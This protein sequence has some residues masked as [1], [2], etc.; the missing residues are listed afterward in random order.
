MKP[1]YSLLLL[2]FVYCGNSAQG[3][4]G[5]HYQAVARNAG[6]G[7]LVSQAIKVRFTIL[8]GNGP[9]ALVQYMERHSTSTTPQGLFTL[10]IGK[11][12]AEAGSFGSIPWNKANQYLRID[13]DAANNNN[14]VTLGAVPFMSVPYAQYA[15][16]GVPG[17]KGDKGDKGDT[18]DKGNKG[19]PGNQGPA[20]AQGIQGLQGAAGPQGIAGPAGPVWAINSIGYNTNGTVAVNTSNTPAT[21]TSTDAVWLAKG[22]SGTN[23]STSFIGTTDAQPL[24]IKTNG[25]AATNERMRITANGQTIINGA[26]LRSTQDALEVFGT[27]YAGAINNFS[28]PINGYSSGSFAGVYGENTG[29][30]QGLLG[31]NI[32]TG[33]GVYGLNSSNGTGVYGM[34]FLAFGVVGQGVAPQG[35][36]VKAITTSATG[37]GLIALG[38][39]IVNFTPYAGG[40]GTSSYGTQAG[41]Y[42]TA[43]NTASGTGIVGLGNNAGPAA[44]SS[45][46][47]VQG[48]GTTYGVAGIVTE[49][50]VGNNHWGGY[51]DFMASSNGY[52][53]VGGR[54]GNTDYAILSG[55]AKSTIV[56][57]E[58][59]RNRIMYCMEAPEVL[60][61]D[62]GTGELKN[63]IAHITLDKLLA[64]NIKVDD[65]H[66][67]KV[68]IQP[69][70]EC[71]GVYVYNKTPDGFDVKELM[72][73]QSNISFTWQIVASR[74]D[75]TDNTGKVV[76]AF[77]DLRFPIGPERV[78]PKKI[79][80]LPA[81]ASGP[82]PLPGRLQ[83]KDPPIYCPPLLKPVPKQTNIIT[84]LQ[85]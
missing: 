31:K 48:I 83:E 2:L 35:A 44:L 66:P 12:T 4:S 65:K 79:E 32:S 76:S 53:W 15:A 46:A 70:G 28:F 77:A 51:F 59:N 68:F 63:G 69:E 36:G 78:I 16:N 18:G 49:P 37:T 43:T 25:S 3:L 80:T 38:N 64:R 11:G 24:L 19:D 5:I 72:K 29:A 81:Q 60:F 33:V 52:A 30:G 57:D 54:T 75:I 10:D 62:Y 6:G 39:S 84:T 55:G 82:S 34:S 41:L 1:V 61:Q 47:G 67:L 58:N 74:A 85:P 50:V 17:A 40:A 42:G 9:A 45:G 73:G 56:K 26:T 21:I 8:D 14:F 13:L 27:G 71:N 7:V 23:P 20:G 22:N